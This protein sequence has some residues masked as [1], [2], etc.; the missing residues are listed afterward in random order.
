M[1]LTIV[2][3]VGIFLASLLVIFL[4]M[5]FTGDQRRATGLVYLRDQSVMFFELGLLY[6]ALAVFLRTSPLL[7]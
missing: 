6:F 5:T 3:S 7:K 1:M 2:K 4:V